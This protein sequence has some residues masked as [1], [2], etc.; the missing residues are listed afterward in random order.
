M[1][2]V[3][4]TGKPAGARKINVTDTGIGIDIAKRVFRLNWVEKATGVIVSL[5]LN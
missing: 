2:A 3:I 1:V 5:Q 4:S